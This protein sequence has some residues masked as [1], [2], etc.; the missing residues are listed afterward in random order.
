MKYPVPMTGTVKAHRGSQELLRYIM[1]A[2]AGA[3]TEGR[4]MLIAQHSKQT[5]CMSQVWTISH[6]AE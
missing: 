6:A 3:D 1:G 4:T 2:S 5:L